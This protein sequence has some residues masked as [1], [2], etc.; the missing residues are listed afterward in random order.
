M[1]TLF[2]ITLDDISSDEALNQD[3]TP[4]IVVTYPNI[5]NEDEAEEKIPII[6]VNK[7]ANIPDISVSEY[8]NSS[9]ESIDIAG[10][11]LQS[12]I[13][14]GDAPNESV[15]RSD[16]SARTTPVPSANITLQ[17]PESSK[18]KM[19]NY[20]FATNIINT[21]LEKKYR[22]VLISFQTDQYTLPKRIE[23][24]VIFYFM[25]WKVFIKLTDCVSLM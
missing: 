17:L 5:D 2:F 10:G 20:P 19:V 22:T 6:E 12:A 16:T 4:E 8:Q 25:R 23:N 21:D 13:K 7:N 9:C 18:L 11:N 14:D 24:Q 15:D 3:I 1:Y